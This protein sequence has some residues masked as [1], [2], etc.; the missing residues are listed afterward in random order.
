MVENLRHHHRYHEKTQQQALIGSNLPFVPDCG[1]TNEDGSCKD[2]HPVQDFA[3]P[4]VLRQECCMRLRLNVMLQEATRLFDEGEFE[5]AAEVYETALQGDCS[6]CQSDLSKEWRVAVFHRLKARCLR[7]GKKYPEALLELANALRRFPRYKDGHFELGLMLLD[8]GYPRVA[9][10]AFERL[11]HID[12]KWPEL[13]DW[14]T[15]S[16]VSMKR[17]EEMKQ[18]MQSVPQLEGS[19]LQFVRAMS[20]GMQQCGF[21]TQNELPSTADHYTFLGVNLDH[22]VDELKKA[23]KRL[24]K[25]YHPDRQGGSNSAFQRVALA[26]ETLIDE[27]RR[28]QYNLG[29]DLKRPIMQD[30]SEGASFHERVERHYFPEHFDFLP[31]GDPFERKRQLHEERKQSQPLESNEPDIPPGSYV[32]SCHGCKLVSEGK[33]LHCSQCLNTRGQRVDSSILLSD[34]TEEEHVGNADGKLTCER[35][36]AQML[37]AGEH[38]ESAEA[39]SNEEN[40]RH[41]L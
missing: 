15:R 22:S 7:R 4:E 20:A 37:N 21:V 31:F 36:P 14:L 26:Y 41:E 2:D 34:C 33:R 19:D 8:A 3:L 24:S 6:D 1:E 12:R 17:D 18:L 25:V 38:Q 9:V 23:Y 13:T 39:V 27:E 28:R 16:H 40:A 30:G 32:G 29:Y 10:A 5:R 35:K 11:L